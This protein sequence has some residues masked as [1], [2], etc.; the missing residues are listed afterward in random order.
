MKSFTNKIPGFKMR[1]SGISDQ[2]KVAT[3]EFTTMLP[4]RIR[5]G[6]KATTIDY[7]IARACSSLAQQLMNMQDVF[8]IDTNF[9]V[10]THTTLIRHSIKILV[11]DK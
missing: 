5:A 4:D 8:E 11:K 2:Y 6:N 9:D 1:S 7:L 10:S 3:V